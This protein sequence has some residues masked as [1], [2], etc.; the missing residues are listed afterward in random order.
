MILPTF[1]DDVRAISASALAEDAGIDGVFVFD[2]L[3]PMSR[4]D[5][6]AISAFVL[7]GALAASTS[8]VALGPLVARVGLVPD[9]VMVAQFR[10]LDRIAPGRVIGALGTGD[11]KSLEE[12][13]SY[14]YQRTS[15]ASRRASLARCA[16]RVAAGGIPVWVGAGAAPTL[17][18]AEEVGAAVN[19]WGAGADE[20]ASQAA[21]TEVTWA[22][23][24]HRDPAQAVVQIRGMAR[25]GAT[26]AVVSWEGDEEG[27]D[28]IISARDSAGI[29]LG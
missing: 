5:R 29:E 1:C 11:A 28:Q 3:W 13:D 24:L 16:K 18:V 17:R 7:L 6:P 26:W 21:R 4:P 25:A 22:G 15:A 9:A 23:N 20:L 12:N 8:R 2:H 19:F 14:G 27:L 10:S